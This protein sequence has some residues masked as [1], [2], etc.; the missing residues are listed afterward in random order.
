MG[1]DLGANTSTYCR[2]ISI[3]TH[4]AGPAQGKV[5]RVL[6]PGWPME[7]PAAADQLPDPVRAHLAYLVLMWK[8]EGDGLYGCARKPHARSWTL[9]YRIPD[10]WVRTMPCATL[11]SA[12]CFLCM[13]PTSTDLCAYDT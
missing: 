1:L 6:D 5:P 13:L 12:F 2:F 11:A 3:D 7:V 8:G 9:R 10:R 4:E